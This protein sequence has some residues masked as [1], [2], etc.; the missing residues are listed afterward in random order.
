[1]SV[2]KVLQ[3][4]S[5]TTI[6]GL[7]HGPTEATPAPFKQS[8]TTEHPIPDP[9]DP[10]RRLYFPM[11]ARGEVRDEHWEETQPTAGAESF[12]QSLSQTQCRHFHERQVRPSF[13]RLY[14]CHFRGTLCTDPTAVPK[15]EHPPPKG[16]NSTSGNL[17]WL[18]TQL[19]SARLASRIRHITKYV[20]LCTWKNNK[21]S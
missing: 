1:M 5:Q 7:S 9:R 12:W 15:D 20:C 14:T 6:Y 8:G 11:Q 3:S 16:E 17:A 10:R 21:P 19:I 13:S 4:V 18:H 2:M